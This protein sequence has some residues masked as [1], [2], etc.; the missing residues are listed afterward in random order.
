ME[1]PVALSSRGGGEDSSKEESPVENVWCRSWIIVGHSG[2][3]R[4][5]LEEPRDDSESS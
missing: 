4:P 1:E 5:V 3:E 2:G